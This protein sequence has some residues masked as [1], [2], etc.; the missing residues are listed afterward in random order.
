MNNLVLRRKD[1][2]DNPTARVPVCLCL[3]TSYSMSGNPIDEL[4]KGVK[5]FYDA[6]KSDEI[7]RYSA[8]IAVVTFG[9]T[10]NQISDFC[11]IDRQ[12]IQKLSASGNTPMGEAVQLGLKLLENRKKEYQNVG[13]DYFQPWLVLMTDGQPTSSWEQIADEVAGLVNSRKLSVF[14]IGVGD[15]A[16][17]NVLARFSPKRQPVKLVG[18]NFCGFFEW[19]SKSVTAVSNSMPGQEIPLPAPTGWLTL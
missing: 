2:I 1:L 18:L 12:Q 16:D 10:P 19:L 13:V 14:A 6:I 9:G 8:E 11:S 3:D 4:N 15:Q 5:L 17:M 7:A